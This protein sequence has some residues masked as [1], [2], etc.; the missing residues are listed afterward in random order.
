MR[1]WQ[2]ENQLDLFRFFSVF[3]TLGFH[4]HQ[5]S[6]GCSEI[7]NGFFDAVFH[8]LAPGLAKTVACA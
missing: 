4:C 6:L 2:L 7:G 3:T 5:N 1:I 8:Q